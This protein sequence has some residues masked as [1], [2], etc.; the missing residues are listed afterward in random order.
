M[1]FIFDRKVRGKV[2]SYRITGYR[3]KKTGKVKQKREYL[4]VRNPE[5]GEVTTP[6]KD[7]WAARNSV[8][9]GVVHAVDKCSSAN[10]LKE[11]LALSL[12]AGD[13]GK[14]FALA[15]YC[16]TEGTPMYLYENWAHSAENLS[17]HAM[18]SQK[19]S[20]FLRRLG[21][22]ER[23]RA[24]FW[25]L[26]S[27]L[28]GR[29]RN[30]VFDITS[31]STYA[32]GLDMDEFGYNRDGE[33]LPQINVGMVYSD[34]PSTPLGYK[35]YPGS[36]GDVSTVKNLLHYLKHDLGLPHSRLVLDRGFFS[37]AN[38]KGLDSAGY[39][40][41][42]PVPSGLRVAKELL[43]ETEGSFNDESAYFEFNGRLMAHAESSRDYAGAFRRFHVFVDF[44]RRNDETKA[45]LAKLKDV[46]DRF[47]GKDF[48]TVEDATLFVESVAKGTAKLYRFRRTA[49]RF[50]IRRDSAAVHERAKR[51]GKI[52]LL[53]KNFGSE[54]LPLLTDYFRRDG[55]EK[56][57]DTLKNEMDSARGRVHSQENFDGR[58]FI[59]MV[60]LVI[61]GE[62]TAR[63]KTNGK[64]VKFKM[65][66]PEI[67]SNLK[68][69]KRTYSAD[70]TSVLGELTK[71][72][73]DIFAVLGIPP[74]E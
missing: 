2:Y 13:G 23:G 58:L 50:S 52:I 68:R 44:Q 15:A 57:F 45:L 27:R 8:V 14:A 42:I 37:V 61:H 34:C 63:I 35:V 70:G 43:M 30:L 53:P 36:V 18:S 54:P 11:T 28:H 12:G 33:S 26:W 21:E 62:M 74:P 55:V 19:V 32:D 40:Y 4:G 24:E 10:R 20:G 60:A 38:L 25:K 56:F 65:A 6:R 64:P 73:R 3:E 31:I 17:V 66:F 41:L 47:E 7:R 9:S 67:V 71:K 46:E 59:H 39:D 29:N 5:T 51:F 1:S 49:G 16:A 48:G 22:N 69:L 72:Q